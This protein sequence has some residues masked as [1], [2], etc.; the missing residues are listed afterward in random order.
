MRTE[1]P[2]APGV[3]QALSGRAVAADFDGGSVTSDAGALLGGLDY[4]RAAFA[5]PVATDA[6]AVRRKTANRC[7][8]FD[9]YGDRLPPCFEAERRALAAR[10]G[11]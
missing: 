7:R 9:G 2:S 5:R 11:R 6:E 1:C 3:F 8:P 10:A 4:P